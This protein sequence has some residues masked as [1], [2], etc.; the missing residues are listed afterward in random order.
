M[1]TKAPQTGTS[2]ERPVEH[3]RDA[4]L[5]G[6]KA[7]NGSH[8]NTGVTKE[9]REKKRSS[10]KKVKNATATLTDL[11]EEFSDEPIDHGQARDNRFLPAALREE[12]TVVEA[13]E[14]EKNIWDQRLM[15]E[16]LRRILAE[17]DSTPEPIP[18]EPF[19]IVT[20]EDIDRAK[21]GLP[22]VEDP[23]EE[24]TVT[25]FEPAFP[26]GDEPPPPPP[27]D[28]GG[29]G[30]DDFSHLPPP[31]AP[32]LVPQR[33]RLNSSLQTAAYSMMGAFTA[34]TALMYGSSL[35]GKA[36]DSSLVFA[37]MVAGAAVPHA[38]RIVRQATNFR[39]G[40]DWQAFRNETGWKGRQCR[41]WEKAGFTPEQ[42][43]AWEREFRSRPGLNADTYPP[44]GDPSTVKQAR[45]FRDLGGPGSERIRPEEAREF[46]QAWITPENVMEWNEK[47]LPA[48]GPKVERAMQRRELRRFMLAAH[49]R[50]AEKTTPGYKS[51]NDSMTNMC[52][53]LGI[54]PLRRYDKNDDGIMQRYN[55]DMS[56]SRAALV[57]SMM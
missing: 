35:S 1:P 56:S 6:G 4:H 52:R 21:E 29:G 2:R 30:G 14:P 7:V 20:R 47:F 23:A 17:G 37:A 42:A 15:P 33:D 28:N 48:S 57:D 26:D 49:T 40:E 19:V 39:L 8:V 55:R 3:D 41:R 43:L 34:A 5:R 51:V 22:P 25:D 53:E 38:T 44:G 9:G 16:R 45:Q 13:V 27:P 11:D 24:I 50:L 46:I 12:N 18:D 31:P 10:G 32:D 54:P 36:S